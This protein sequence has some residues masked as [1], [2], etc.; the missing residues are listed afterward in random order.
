[1]ARSVADD[2]VSQPAVDIVRLQVVLVA[3]CIHAFPQL[4]PRSD[5]ALATNMTN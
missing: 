5:A 1:M 4:P 3:V 2:I